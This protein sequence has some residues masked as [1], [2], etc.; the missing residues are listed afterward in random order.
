MQKL[1]TIHINFHQKQ[2]A[3]IL[4]ELCQ[5]G[6]ML[7]SQQL[8]VQGRKY[9]HNKINTFIVCVFFVY[10]SRQ[11]A[12][13]AGTSIR[14]TGGQVAQVAEVCS[15][16]KYNPS[17]SWDYDISVLKLSKSLELGSS[18]QTI[19]LVPQ[20]EEVETGTLGTVSGWGRTS[21]SSPI[22]PKILQAVDIPKVDDE[23][24]AAIYYPRN[25]TSRMICYGYE[26][27]K[28]SCSVNQTC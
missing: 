7:L 13:R 19:Q 3:H 20:E 6:Q 11:L 9:P 18:V 23:E 27:G 15:H 14:G 17:N 1:K 4:V 22:L 16:P 28:G 21:T 12:V 2:V 10:S 8:I 24:C 25:I 5:S 26:G